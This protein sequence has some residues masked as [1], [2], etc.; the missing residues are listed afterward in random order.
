MPISACDSCTEQHWSEVKAIISDAV[1][2]V[3]FTANLVS[4]ADDV[5]II[6]KRIIQNLYDNPIVVCDVSAKN[7]N[8]MFELGMRLAFDKPTIIVKDDETTYSFDTSPIEH[9]EYPRDLRFAKIVEFKK[10]L[11]AKIAATVKQSETDPNYITFLKHFGKFAVANLETTEVSKEDF[12]IEEL[13]ELRRAIG[14]RDSIAEREYQRM[15][16]R[17]ML[18]RKSLAGANSS[19]KRKLSALIENRVMEA[20]SAHHPKDNAV[21]IAELDVE[22]VR[23]IMNDPELRSL[24]DNP[25]EVE[26]M[27]HKTIRAF[28]G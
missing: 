17:D 23:K 2:S 7:P 16:E 15:M 19:R 26:E 11:G 28:V 5:G 1:E 6:Q 21:A 18:E 8:V 9:L 25:A 4:D 24:V 13:R 27:V 12:I 3:G 14:R 22:V 20:L 10:N